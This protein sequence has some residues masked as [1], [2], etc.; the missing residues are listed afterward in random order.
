MELMGCFSA[1]EVQQAASR[2]CAALAW[3]GSEAC[4]ALLDADIGC[5]LQQHIKEPETT[6]CMFEN[7]AL[8]VSALAS[9]AGEVCHPPSLVH[10]LFIS[11][12][13][14]AAAALLCWHVS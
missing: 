9:T 12:A 6:L 5:K 11:S 13:V 3:T 14:A 8:V 4:S 7:A 2:V 1:P 10:H